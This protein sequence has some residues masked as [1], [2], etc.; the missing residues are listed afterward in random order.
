MKKILAL[1]IVIA[2]VSCDNPGTKKEKTTK[3]TT[4]E[5]V[6]NNYAVVWDVLTDDHNYVMKYLPEQV[7]EFNQLF[8]DG[9]IENAYLNNYEYVKLN[10]DAALASVMFFVKAESVIAAQAIVDKMSFV[11]NKVATYNV[12]PVGGKWLDRKP[13]ADD[14]KKYSFA[15]VWFLTADEATV[16]KS[17]EKQSDMVI[18]LWEEGI[19]ENAYFAA[20]NAFENRSLSPGMVFFVNT[21]TEEAAR[22]ICDGLVFSKEGVAKYKIFP[23]G[24][25]WLG[26]SK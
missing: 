4:V 25:F 23:V 7:E 8:A 20:E 1:I 12:Y 5:T 17:V 6:T 19:I 11:R 21:D 10:N 26:S 18:A 14:D 2:M 9:I 15:T 16:K 13:A 24:T 3:A 22:E